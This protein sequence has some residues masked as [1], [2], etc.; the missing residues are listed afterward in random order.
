MNA[1]QQNAIPGIRCGK[2]LGRI[3][4]ENNANSRR[5][6]ARLYPGS[7]W[8]PPKVCDACVL[9]TILNWPDEEETGGAK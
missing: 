1:V 7:E 5:M 8:K 3:S 2:C 6:Q 4:D 9:E